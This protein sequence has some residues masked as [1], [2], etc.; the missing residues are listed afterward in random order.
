MDTINN[1]IPIA[2]EDC[3]ADDKENSFNFANQSHHLIKRNQI[4]ALEK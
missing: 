4:S 1:S 2:W 3:L